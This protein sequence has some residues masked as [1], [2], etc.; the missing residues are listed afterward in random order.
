M[1]TF[2]SPKKQNFFMRTAKT[3]DCAIAQADLS[4]HCEH[5]LEGTFS[6]I[7]VHLPSC[8][9]QLY[10]A[11]SLDMLDTITEEHKEKNIINQTLEFYKPE[12]DKFNFKKRRPYAVFDLALKRDIDEEKSKRYGRKMDIAF[13]FESNRSS[14]I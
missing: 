5:M 14:V 7:A 9:L 4:L 13:A 8:V 10:H 11:A 12:Y 1:S 6:D 3:D 2:R